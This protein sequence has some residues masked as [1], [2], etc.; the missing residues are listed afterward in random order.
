SLESESDLTAGLITSLGI[1]YTCA[2]G[3]SLEQVGARLGNVDVLF[4]ATGAAPV[5]FQALEALGHNGVLVLLGLPGRPSALEVDAA[6]V[7]P[8]PG[9]RHQGVIRTHKA[10]D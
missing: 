10:R 8:P 9:L 3:A 7:V 6:A 1:G 2:S 5:T 4:E